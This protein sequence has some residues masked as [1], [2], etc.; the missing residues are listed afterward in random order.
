MLASVIPRGKETLQRIAGW[1]GECLAI[2][3]MPRFQPSFRGEDNA[4]RRVLPRRQAGLRAHVS[5]LEET[6]GDS[7]RSAVLLTSAAIGTTVASCPIF[8]PHTDADIENA[9]QEDQDKQVDQEQIFSHTKRLERAGTVHRCVELGLG[10]RDGVL[11]C[12]RSANQGGTLPL[13][14]P[15]VVIRL[16][17]LPSF[18]L[19]AASIAKR[20][21]H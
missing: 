5:L 4:D 19:G 13:R 20:H 11:E 7:H 6:H 1:T 12:C 21:T 2:S 17:P 16:D 18:F 3:E 8:A 14:L 10:S 9:E 15:I